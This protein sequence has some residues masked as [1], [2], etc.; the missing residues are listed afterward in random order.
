MLVDRALEQVHLRPDGVSEVR[1]HDVVEDEVYLKL[2]G[3]RP[4]SS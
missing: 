1:G 3:R 4:Y 2:A